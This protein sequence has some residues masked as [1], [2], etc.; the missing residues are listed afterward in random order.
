[1]VKPLVLGVTGAS[2]A[3]IVPHLIATSPFPLHLIFSPWGKKVY[4]KEVGP[5]SSLPSELPIW[6]ADQLDSPLASGSNPTAGMVIAPCSLNTASKIAL[7]IAD[8][9]ITRAGQVHLKEKR[10]FILAIR[11]TPLPWVALD[12]LARLASMGAII[13]PLTPPFYEKKSSIDQLL[14]ALAK[15][16]WQ[17]FGHPYPQGY[18]HDLLEP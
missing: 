4:E 1:M 12:N 2:G 7:G 13:F 8:D 15:R 9:L 6:E 5:L 14:E 3:G 17:L 18:R 11:E 10:P 16:I